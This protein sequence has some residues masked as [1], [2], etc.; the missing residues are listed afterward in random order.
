MRTPRN[1]EITRAR[2]VRG[3]IGGRTVR[4]LAFSRPLNVLGA[5]A[6]AVNPSPASHLEAPTGR[7]PK[8]PC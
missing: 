2:A 3:V 5:H 1:D 6:D 4:K 7:Q 8:G